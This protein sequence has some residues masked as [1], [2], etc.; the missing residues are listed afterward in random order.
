MY[1]E[2]GVMQLDE[3]CKT[4]AKIAARAQRFAKESMYI[5]YK[6]NQYTIRTDIY[7]SFNIFPDKPQSSPAGKGKNRPTMK[8]RLGGFANRPAQSSPSNGILWT[9]DTTGNTG[10]NSYEDYD[11]SGAVVIG[12][13]SDLEKR[14]LRLTSVR[15]SFIESRKLDNNNKLVF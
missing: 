5:I 9:L 15:K 1:S 6:Y 12:T 14:Y 7:I 13:C 10:T 8:S 2:Y 4:T 3:D 11:W